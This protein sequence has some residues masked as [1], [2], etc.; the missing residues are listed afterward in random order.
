[1][2]LR[3]F[4][5]VNQKASDR[6]RQSLFSHRSRFFKLTRVEA[7]HARSTFFKRAR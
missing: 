1:V 7:S 6:R 4:G 2:P 3:V 5:N